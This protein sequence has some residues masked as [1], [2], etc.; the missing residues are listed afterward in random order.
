MRCH[1]S[2]EVGLFGVQIISIHYGGGWGEGG[3]DKCLLIFKFP[4]VEDKIYE[5][6]DDI[7]VDIFHESFDG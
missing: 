3:G 2:C 4:F 6:F 7:L 5:V 1:A